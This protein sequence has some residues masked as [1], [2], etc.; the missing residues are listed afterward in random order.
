MSFKCLTIYIWFGFQTLVEVE[1]NIL[2]PP[3]GSPQHLENL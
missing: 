2:A 1:D 3:Q